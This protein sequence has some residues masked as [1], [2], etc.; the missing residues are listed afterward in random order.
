MPVTALLARNKNVKDEEADDDFD[1]F[2]E[3]FL[4]SS[5]P[6]TNFGSESVPEG[7]R[8]INEYLNVLRQPF[9]DWAINGGS[10]GLLTRLLILY[11]V[12]FG[13]VCY[14]I[15]GATYDTQ[16]GNFMLPKIASANV[17]ALLLVLLLLVR[18]YSGW[19]YVGS[20]L[21]S[22]VIE[23]EETGWFDG[24]FQLKSDNE[25]KR[26]MFLYNNK[27]K[28]IV[29]RLKTFTLGAAGMW[30]ASCIALKVTTSSMPLFDQYNPDMLEQLSYDDKLA[31]TAAKRTLGRPTYCD[32]RYYQAV[33]GGSGC[34]F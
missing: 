16:P 13:V 27:V 14:P 15:A 25:Y 23:Y 32:S 2:S 1:L 22:K 24:D 12:I 7:Q 20:R 9:F 17:G 3:N 26:D 19:G 29:G 30:V 6:Q 18:L 4:S 34:N 11:S 21:T 10:R 28:P 8:P 5:T 31:E 33:A